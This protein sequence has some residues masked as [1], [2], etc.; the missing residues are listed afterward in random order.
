MRAPRVGDAS[1]LEPVLPSTYSHIRN[2]GEFA[3]SL[4]ST[5]R[6]GSTRPLCASR[7]LL[8]CVIVS[9]WLR[10]ELL[11]LALQIKHPRARPDVAGTIETLF[12]ASNRL[13]FSRAAMSSR[14][15]LC[16]LARRS[17]LRRRARGRVLSLLSESHAA[18][19]RDARLRSIGPLALYA[20]LPQEGRRARVRPPRTDRRARGVPRRARRV[21]ALGAALPL[22]HVADGGVV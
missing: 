13:Q 5:G 22:R 20:V 6:P 16:S 21:R 17:H 8:M 15:V 10:S 1:I 4:S 11:T 2:P 14:A 9:V 19:V 3:S 12:Q 18:T 7:R